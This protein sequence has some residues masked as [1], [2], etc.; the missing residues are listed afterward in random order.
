MVGSAI[1]KSA[2]QSSCMLPNAS[3]ILRMKRATPSAGT[4]LRLAGSAHLPLS[5]CQPFIVAGFEVK[6]TDRQTDR[7]NNLCMKI[8][9]VG[10]SL[11][12]LGH[13]NPC[14]SVIRN[15]VT[16][17]DILGCSWWPGIFFGATAY[18]GTPLC[19]AEQWRNSYA[20]WVGE[21]AGTR[22]EGHPFA[23][24]TRA[25]LSRNII[26]EARKTKNVP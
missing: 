25:I 22:A 10:E 1:L 8:F 21:P 23:R 6:R 24:A 4:S 13:R 3:T 15:I 5:L 14:P 9:K 26:L 16:A 17:R 12:S 2:A 18:L 7:P 20:F 11:H 19:T